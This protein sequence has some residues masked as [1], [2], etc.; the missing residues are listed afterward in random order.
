MAPRPLKKKRY[1]ALRPHVARIVKVA[2][3]P[4]H[5]NG[6]YMDDPHRIPLF[7]SSNTKA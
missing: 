5:V 3:Y 2:E 6:A 4:V 7:R 1:A